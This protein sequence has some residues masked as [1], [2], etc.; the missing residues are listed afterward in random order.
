MLPIYCTY[1]MGYIPSASELLHRLLGKHKYS[2]LEFIKDGLAD[3]EIKLGDSGLG[4][5]QVI[6][7]GGVCL[8]CLPDVS[9]LLPVSIQLIRA[10]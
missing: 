8:S 3:Q 1:S 9:A 5:Q 10:Y 2:F 6:L 4:N 7:Q